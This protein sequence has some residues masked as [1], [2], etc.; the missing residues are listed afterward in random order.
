MYADYVCFACWSPKAASVIAE[1]KL[2]RNLVHEDH[3][4]GIRTLAYCICMYHASLQL[5]IPTDCE[6]KSSTVCNS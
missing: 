3:C 5:I 6:L 2:L 4:H 1:T